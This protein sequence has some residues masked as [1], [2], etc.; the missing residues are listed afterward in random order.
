[1]FGQDFSKLLEAA[2]TLTRF[3]SYSISPSITANDTAGKLN[4]AGAS[5]SL[6]AR[7]V[8]SCALT[9]VAGTAQHGGLVTLRLVFSRSGENVTDLHQVQVE[10]VP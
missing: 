9:Y 5:S 4:A 10:N 8:S 2:N 3:W 6:V 7:D 1:K